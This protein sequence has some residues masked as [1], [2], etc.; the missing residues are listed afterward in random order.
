MVSKLKFLIA[1]VLAFLVGGVV[2]LA[3]G[4]CGGFRFG[5][6]FILNNCIPK[7]AREVVSRVAILKQ[8]RAGKRDQ[9]IEALEAGLND[10][11]IL[12]DPVTPYPGLN[13]NTT[14]DIKKAISAAKEYRSAHPR[15]S[16][17]RDMRDEM[18]R[19]LF[20]RENKP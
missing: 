9:A 15:Q 12:F 8:L 13:G 5:M 19:N 1:L 6:S 4:G 10:A 2:G 18:V 20:S 17:Q 16:K 7:D 14:A 11:L 3:A